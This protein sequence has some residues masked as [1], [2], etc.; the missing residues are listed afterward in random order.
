MAKNYGCCTDKSCTLDTCMGLPS[1]KTCGD[2][3]HIARCKAFGFSC[4]D[5][6]YCDFFPRRFRQR[7]EASSYS[8]VR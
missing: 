7:D 4:P 6:K 2:C 3:A 1:D 8:E 5:R